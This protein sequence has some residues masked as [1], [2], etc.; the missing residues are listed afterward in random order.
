MLRHII[1][2]TS[3]SCR[4]GR[5]S[6]LQHTSCRFYNL[7]RALPSA[8][9]L[10][11]A[12][13]A[14]AVCL[15]YLPAEVLLRRRSP[16]CP[17]IPWDSFASLGIPGRP[18][19]GALQ[20]Q[21]H[22]LDILVLVDPCTWSQEAKLV[23]AVHNDAYDA[24][25]PGCPGVLAV[26]GLWGSSAPLLLYCYSFQCRYEPILASDLYNKSFFGKGFLPA[27]GNSF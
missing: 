26:W 21:L 16:G 18:W 24:L 23:P 12:Q 19:G 14:C 5:H 2:S 8:R 1:A 27:L 15:S 3:S 7:G 11:L 4:L 10:S 25:C 22:G 6:L 20:Q 13:L 9:A 17:G